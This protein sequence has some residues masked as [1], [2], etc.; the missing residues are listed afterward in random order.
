MYRIPLIS[1]NGRI[2][3]KR[4]AVNTVYWGSII[5]MPFPPGTDSQEREHRELEIFHRVATLVICMAP[6]DF[7]PTNNVIMSI[8]F[9][10]ITSPLHLDCQADHH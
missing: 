2:K 8:K 7:C 1:I 5:L 6:C 9:L 3:G 4:K 10:Y